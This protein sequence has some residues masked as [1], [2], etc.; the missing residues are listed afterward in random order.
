MLVTN[1]WNSESNVKKAFLVIAAYN[2]DAKFIHDNLMEQGKK[3][4]AQAS[5]VANENLSVAERHNKY[6]TVKWLR[7][8]NDNLRRLVAELEE[9]TQDRSSVYEQFRL[10]HY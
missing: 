6:S 2:F 7:D 8:D 3:E 4:F 1:R 9:K 10:G 5:R